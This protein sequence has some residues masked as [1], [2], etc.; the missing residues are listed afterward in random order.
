MHTLASSNLPSKVWLSCSSSE[1]WPCSYGIKSIKE[2]RL[3]TGPISNASTKANPTV[4][5]RRNQRTTGNNSVEP[6]DAHYAS[7]CPKTVRSQ[8]RLRPITFE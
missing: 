4:I 3:A 1:P 6:H 2:A 7:C 8:G 5:S